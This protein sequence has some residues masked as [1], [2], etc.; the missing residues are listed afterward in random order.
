[1][2]IEYFGDYSCIDNGRVVGLLLRF[3]LSTSFFVVIVN[4]MRTFWLVNGWI[5]LISSYSQWT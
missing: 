5:V 1:M 3:L 2:Q 4:N